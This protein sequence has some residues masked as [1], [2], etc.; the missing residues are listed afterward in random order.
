MADVLFRYVDYWFCG[1][2]FA[3]ECRP[4]IYSY[5]VEK[6]T[7]KGVWVRDEN[8][9]GYDAK[10]KKWGKLRFFLSGATKRFAY[11]TKEE[12]LDSYVQRKKR[13]VRIL[14]SQLDDA[15]E[16]LQQAL[17]MQVVHLSIK[18]QLQ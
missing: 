16:L 3:T 1:D 13:Q 15:K 11:P 5:A 17:I 6:V 12:A 14:S 10:A 4:E 18:E 9:G 8:R 7:A 2:E